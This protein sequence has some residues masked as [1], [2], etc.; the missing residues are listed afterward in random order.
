MKP[1]SIYLEEDITK[2]VEFPLAGKFVDIRYGRFK[3]CGELD[4]NAPPNTNVEESPVPTAVPSQPWS[5]PRP[6]TNAAG[7]SSASGSSFSR[8]KTSQP[9]EAFLKRSFPYVALG[10]DQSGRNIIVESTINNVYVKI[11][12]NAVSGQAIL[13]VMATKIGC[14]VADLNLLDVKFIEVSDDK[15]EV[16][17]ILQ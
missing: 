16:K 5:L 6:W 1:T 4:K 9:Y 17:V 8:K 11:P 10:L 15:G 3:C 14:E 7:S 2:N 13:S 12:E